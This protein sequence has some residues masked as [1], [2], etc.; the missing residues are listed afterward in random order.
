MISKF[1]FYWR[2]KHRLI[3]ELKDSQLLFGETLRD[4]GD[5]SSWLD[6]GCGHQILPDYFKEVETDL[7]DSAERLVGLDFE[8][9]SLRKN[10]TID[11]LLRGDISHLPFKDGSFSL[12]SSNMV[13]EHLKEP[14]AQLREVSRILN[15]GGKLIFH[16]P[17]VRGYSTFL[18]KLIPEFL[19]E[20]LV[21][22]LQGRAED[23]VFPAYY[24]INSESEIRRLAR[25]SGFRVSE[26]RLVCSSAVL[27]KIPPLVVFELLWIKLL[28]R[29]SFRALRPYFIVTLEK[30]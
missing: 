27:F 10:K 4:L 24:R 14:A 28:M 17:N 5:V 15:K 16:T 18:A 7:M 9:V 25:S 12:V 2:T 6:L 1:T 23:D 29:K 20:K 26:I 21:F 30:V 8:M 13:F 11:L 22:L 19:K 3:P